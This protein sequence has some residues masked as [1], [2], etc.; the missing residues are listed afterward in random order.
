MN[1]IEKYEVGILLAL[2]VYFQ[3]AATN[4]NPTLGTI[5]AIFS[6]ASAVFIIIDPKRSIRFRKENDSLLGSIAVGAFA[7]VALIAIGNFIII[8]G[9]EKIV[10][11]LGSTTP[12]LSDSPFFNKLSFG[13]AVPFAETYFFFIVMFDVFASLINV[14]IDRNN[15]KNPKLIGLI[16]AISF[17]FM[18]FHL[19]VKGI[20]NIPILG[21]VFTMAVISMLLVT[22]FRDGEK[23]TYFHCISNLSALLL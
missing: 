23:A 6:L 13:V 2:V 20:G 7:Y 9:L 16:G 12:V 11:L 8:P 1:K 22:Y 10:Q 4:I 3:F 18:F 19:T 21:L 15:L 14:E 5:Y 17:A